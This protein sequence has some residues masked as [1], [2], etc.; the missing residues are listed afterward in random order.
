MGFCYSA[1]PT[2]TPIILST[3]D[4][5]ANLHSHTLHSLN[6]AISQYISLFLRCVR[7]SEAQRIT[8]KNNNNLIGL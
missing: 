2:N 3:A 6:L 1:P 7:N 4:S 8:S 5:L